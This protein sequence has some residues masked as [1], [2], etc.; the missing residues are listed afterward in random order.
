MRK[1]TRV[2]VE[3]KNP[4]YA[5]VELQER[6]S[7]LVT[8]SR[9]AGMNLTSFAKAISD[10]TIVTGQEGPDM[11]YGGK[12]TVNTDYKTV[13]KINQLVEIY[14]VFASW[15]IKVTEINKV[16]PT[17]QAT[18]KKK[19]NKMAV[20]KS[21]AKKKKPAAKKKKAAAKKKPAAKKK[22]AAAKKKPAAKKK[23][24]AAKKKPAAKKK[25]AAAKKKPAAKKKK[26]AAKKK[27]AVKKKK[28]AAKKKPA[29]K[30]KRAKKR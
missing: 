16:K 24:A 17:R 20:K 30:K 27:P 3:F 2:R 18:N 11:R 14:P 22:K 1:S 6:L 23:K 21:G 19:E 28:A 13:T 26:A 9:Y 12:I 10:S 5:D 4:R 25:K 15:D 7:E 8:Y 29:A